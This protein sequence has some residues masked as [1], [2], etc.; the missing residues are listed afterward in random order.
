MAPFFIAPLKLIQY[1]NEAHRLRNIFFAGIRL[2]IWGQIEKS[3]D[4]IFI[5]ILEQLAILVPQYYFSDCT[6]RCIKHLIL[7]WVLLCIPDLYI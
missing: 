4:N 3:L 5:A 2:S 6:L 7:D 1:L